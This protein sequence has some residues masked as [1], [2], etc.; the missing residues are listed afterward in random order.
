MRGWRR[1]SV[2]VT[3][4]ILTFDSRYPDVDR[5]SL[6]ENFRSSEGVVLTARDFIAKNNTR[7]PK[8]MKPASAQAYGK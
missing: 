6:V 7:L 5:I 1:Y 8:A 3:T 4:N 2:P